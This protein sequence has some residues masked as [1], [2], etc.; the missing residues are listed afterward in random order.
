MIDLLNT[1]E[2]ASLL[3]LKPNTLDKMRMQKRGPTYVKLGRRVFYRRG[4]LH[5]WVDQNT[6]RPVKE[7]LVFSGV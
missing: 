3:K 6:H 2:A 4:D 1:Q 7:H 5:L